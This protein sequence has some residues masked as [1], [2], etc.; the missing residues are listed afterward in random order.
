MADVNGVENGVNGI[1]NGTS[2]G[3]TVQRTKLGSIGPNGYPRLPPI[4]R[5]QRKMEDP[6]ANNIHLI[7]LISTWISNVN[8]SYA[9]VF[10][11]FNEFS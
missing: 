5:P 6:Y 8:L 2:G 1:P 7:T 4:N 11:V 3:P 9:M 10:I